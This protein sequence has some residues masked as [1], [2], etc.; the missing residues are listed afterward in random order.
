TLAVPLNVVVVVVIW[1]LANMAE[2]A[3][4][5]SLDYVAHSMAA[6]V[7]AEF[8][9]YIALG[10]VLSQDPALQED[11]LDTFE[12]KLRQQPTA[13]PNAW[14]VVADLDGQQL[15]NTGVPQGRPLP[16]RTTEGIAAQ[17][18]AFEINKVV[19]SDLFQ[20]PVSGNWMASTN[21]PIFRNGAPFRSLALS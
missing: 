13:G 12:G 14:A 16:P 19:V 1:L 21:I 15:I 5:K 8:G 9:K 18:K 3:Q 10:A 20:G 2:E 11:N 7:D 17:N 6:A 4:R